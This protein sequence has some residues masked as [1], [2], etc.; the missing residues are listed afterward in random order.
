MNTEAHLE[1]LHT[2]KVAWQERGW[3]RPDVLLVSGSGLA[4]DLPGRTDHR[5]ELADVVPFAV[6]G[7]IGHP[8]QVEIL[9]PIPGRFVCYQRGRLHSYQGYDANQ[10]VFMVRLLKLLGGSV[11]VMT[12]AAGGIRPE[13]RPGNLVA[14]EDH[15]NLIGLNPLRGDLPAD[16]GPPFPDMTNAYDPELLRLI[17]EVAS[18]LDIPLANGVYAGLAGPSYETPAEVRMLRN[19]GAGVVGM[20][21]V[22]EVIAA[23]HMS[24]RCLCVSLVS[25]LAAGVAGEPLHHDEILEAIQEAAGRVRDL[26]S[27]LLTRAELYDS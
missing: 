21:T 25:N 12:N 18:K 23:R 8:L 1:Q 24:V 13:Q 2:A 3:P 26:L 7:V 10:T 4:V 17:G 16:W 5:A 27:K 22:L 14:I 20:S 19:L 15:L 9:E 6:R 11:L